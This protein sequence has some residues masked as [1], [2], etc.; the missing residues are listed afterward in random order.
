MW[1]DLIVSHYEVLPGALTVVLWERDLRRHGKTFRD[2]SSVECFA[3]RCLLM[4]K[5]E[6]SSNWKGLSD[7]FHTVSELL[8]QIILSI[9]DTIHSANQI[10]IQKENFMKFSAYLEKTA[11]VLRELSGLNSDYSESLRNAVEILNRKTKIAKRLV[12][13]CNKKSKVYLLLNCHRIVSHLEDS[14]KEISQALSLIPLA[15]LGEALSLIPLAS[16]GV[17]L[18][19]SDKISQLCK[20]MLDSEYQAVMEQ[21]ILD[22]I[23]SARQEGNVDR[24]WANNLLFHIAE[25]VGISTEKLALK[26]EVEEFKNEVEDLKLRKDIADIIKM[27]QII[28]LLENADATTSHEE[29]ERKYFSRRNSLGRQPLQPLQSFYCPIT[30]DIMVD[31][32]EISSGKTF[33][34]AAIEKWFTEGHSS[35]PLTC[36]PLDTFVLQPN[37]PLRKSIAE[38]R[39]RNNLITIVSIKSKLQSTEDQEVLQSLEKLQGLLVERDL[40]REW[41]L[42]EDYVPVLIELLGAKDQEIRTHALAILCI[43]AKDSEVNREKIAKVNLALEMIV[44]SLARQI[45]ERIH[46]VRD[47]IGNIQGCILLLVTTSN[48][49]DNDAANKAEELLQNLSFLNQNVIQM[50][51]ANYFK[52]LLQLLSSG[53]KDLKLILA[54]TLSEIELTEHNKVSLFRDGA[55]EPLL[56]LLAYDDLEVK[57][58][59]IKALNNLSNVP[60]NGIQMIREGA[61]EP[62]FELLYRHSL[63]PPSLREQPHSSAELR[64]KLRQLSAVQVLVQLCELDNHIVRANAVKLFCFLT[65]DGDEGTFLEHVGQRCIDTLLKIIK[66]PSDLEEVAAA[67]GVISNLPK[68]PQITLWLLDAGALEVISTCLNAESRNAS[69]RMKII[70]YAVAALCRFTAPSNQKWQNRVAKAGIIPVLVQLLVSGTALTK[71]YAAISLKQFS[72]SSTALSNRGCF[73]FCMAAPVKSCPAHLGICTVESSF[74]ILEA[75][76]LEPLVRMLGERDPGV[77]EASLDALLT[78]VDVERLQTGTKVLAEANAIIPIIKLLGS[79]SSSIQEKTLK[80]LER[81]FRLVELEQNYGASAQM[82]LVEITQRGSSHMKSLAAKVLAQL[83]LLNGQSSYF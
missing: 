36:T 79:S 43:L 76:A 13:E 48:S 11:S 49:D 20:N 4:M 27:E 46:L 56:E 29:R 14:T 72:E 3:Q 12:L 50:A 80:A 82:L 25:A 58:V 53:E 2:Q 32:V 30:Q 39:D 18:S 65:Q 9:F 31:P 23:E 16:L 38:W 61:L 21:E 60:Q 77:C 28:A 6:I 17:S 40:H 47:S 33:E 59:A 70:E 35:C 63:L 1:F 10:V 26:K 81:I 67:M 8:S 41:A 83:N 37:K 73:Q 45:G 44:R 78:L 54:G 5:V 42:M 24:S 15:S 22:K 62:L 19:I 57:K 52:P 64:T 55:L 34:R 7:M 75:N 68:D 51:K 74:C 69:Y 71:Q 66:T